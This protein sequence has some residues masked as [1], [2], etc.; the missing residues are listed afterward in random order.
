MKPWNYCFFLLSREKSICW[1]SAVSK[2]PFYIFLWFDP[3]A[4]YFIDSFSHA[5][6]SIFWFIEKHIGFGTL[7]KHNIM[8]YWIM[9]PCTDRESICIFYIALSLEPVYKAVQVCKNVFNIKTKNIC[10]FYIFSKSHFFFGDWL[11]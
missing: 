2:K 7:C 4:R 5:A 8:L 1:C 11:L 6:S 3:W 9:D 10:V